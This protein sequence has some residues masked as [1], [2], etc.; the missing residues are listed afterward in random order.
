M[1]FEHRLLVGFGEIKAIVFECNNCKTRVSIP[2][3][4]FSGAPL[5]CPKQHDWK[6]GESTVGEVPVFKG[7][8]LLFKRMGSDDF[9]KQVG[10]RVFLEFEDAE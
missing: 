7:L 9:Q 5:T 3:E 8:A 6:G 2:M 4:E 1:T 10:F